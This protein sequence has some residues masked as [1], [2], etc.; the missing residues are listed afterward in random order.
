MIDYFSGL[1][2]CKKM[3]HLLTVMMMAFAIGAF[4]QSK[5]KNF[6]LTRSIEL[7]EKKS[8]ISKVIGSEN[9][10]IYVVG[11]AD[12]LVVQK[13]DHKGQVVKS[14]LLEDLKFEKKLDKV[15]VDAVIFNHRLFLRFKVYDRTSKVTHMI[16]EEYDINDLTFINAVIDEKVSN[17]G[18]KESPSY[19]FSV[20]S[21]MSEQD[22]YGF[23]VSPDGK[24]LM[25]FSSSQHTEKEE[26]EDVQISVF[27]AELNMAWSEKFDLPNK[28]VSFGIQKGFV[29]NNGGAHIIGVDSDVDDSS[30]GKRRMML[31]SYTGKGTSK[32]Q[33]DLLNDE[34]LGR[35][36]A[37]MYNANDLMVVGFIGKDPKKWKLD[38]FS[39]K[40]NLTSDNSPEVL[41]YPISNDYVYSVENTFHK[42]AIEEGGEVEKPTG[43]FDY[44]IFPVQVFEDGTYTIL[45][46]FSD[47][48]F[49]TVSTGSSTSQ[50]NYDRGLDA[51]AFHFDAAGK[52]LWQNKVD[53]QFVNIEGKFTSLVVNRCGNDIVIVYNTTDIHAPKKQDTSVN[54]AVISKDGT[55]KEEV[56]EFGEEKELMLLNSEVNLAMRNCESMLILQNRRDYHIAFL[57]RVK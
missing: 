17:D 10:H 32:N 30:S 38:L 31:L 11:Y 55:T 3:K 2:F 1:I 7:S 25:C 52:A 14:V 51:I 28:A 6:K 45:F 34:I 46:E 27:D 22:E 42:G 50:V 23:S 41:R 53:R 49:K 16:L 12:G 9:D 26:S 29:D 37:S 40:V 48:F 54:V 57:E 8:S 56:L 24:Y 43:L 33:R 47:S 21:S 15:F 44:N 36:T 13:I 18:K 39:I 5:S 35:W 20:I 4:A 19:G